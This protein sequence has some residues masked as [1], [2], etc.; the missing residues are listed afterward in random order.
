MKKYFKD[1]VFIKKLG[2]NISRLR[3]AQRIS[4]SQLAFEAG[5]PLMQIS[6]IERGVINTSVSNIF[7]I[8]QVLDIETKELFDFTGLKQKSKVVSK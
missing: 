5:I 1:E 7:V 2:K 6:R 8:S 4:Q 3:K